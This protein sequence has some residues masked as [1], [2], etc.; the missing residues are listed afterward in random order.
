M[1]W[2]AHIVTMIV[3]TMLILKSNVVVVTFPRK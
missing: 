2:T 1:V 3:A